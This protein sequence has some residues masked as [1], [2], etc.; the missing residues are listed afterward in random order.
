MVP[1]R[2]T[3]L[4]HGAGCACKLSLD[5]LRGI[6]STLPAMG[7][8]PEGIDVIVGFGDR[9]DAA[10]WRSGTD[11][12]LSVATTDFFTPIVDDPRDWGRI[13][14]TNAV[15]D[16]YAMG[17]VPRVALNLVGWPRALPFEL[18]SGVLGGAQE[19]AAAAGYGVLG[20][21]SIDSAEPF[22]GLAVYGDVAEDELLT[23]AGARPD[24]VLVLTKPIGT[25]I[26]MTASKHAEAG[27]TVPGFAGAV[28]SMTTLNAAAGRLAVQ[29]NVSA[30]TD[31]TGFGLLGHLHGMSSASSL[32]ARVDAAAVPLLYGA[33]DL[34]KAGFVPDG[35]KRNAE[36]SR[37]YVIDGESPL[38]ET[39]RIM[40]SDAQTSGG[41][42]LAVA[43][44]VADALI[45]EFRAI[46]LPAARIGS[47]K[48]GRP[49]AVRVR[50][51]V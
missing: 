34:L 7:S 44:E 9:D 35:T 39:T 26:I 14:A 41:L 12:R 11:G 8:A 43:P 36:Q 17:G 20:G 37:A 24:D 25:G 15:S 50:G 5:E 42:L 4:S 22:F 48:E 49:G 6:L 40:L 19:V 30:A 1:T 3:S 29:R 13:A 51:A 16:I 47:F 18:L 23:N 45:D 46:G 33:L 31:V 2:L 38:D 27:G 21:H 28:A 10:V 32:E